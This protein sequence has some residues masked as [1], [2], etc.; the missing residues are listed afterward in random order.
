MWIIFKLRIISMNSNIRELDSI[1]HWIYGSGFAIQSLCF[2]SIVQKS[3]MIFEF[4][5][6]K[7]GFENKTSARHTIPM[8]YHIVFT[9]CFYFNENVSSG[10]N[11]VYTFDMFSKITT[12]LRVFCESPF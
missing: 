2:V 11:A 1:P 12:A 8:K 9:V 4:S 7:N 3:R 5:W 6:K 10:L